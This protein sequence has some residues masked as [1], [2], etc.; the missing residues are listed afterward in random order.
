MERLKAI[1]MVFA[2][3]TLEHWTVVF[4]ASRNLKELYWV[5]NQLLRSKGVLYGL[6][7][8]KV[9][10]FS[11]SSLDIPDHFFDTLP[12][13]EVLLLDNIQLETLS[14]VDSL[15]RLLRNLKHLRYL[16]VSKNELNSLHLTFASTPNI[17]HLILSQNRF[18]N[19]P[20]DIEATGKLQFLDLSYNAI[21]F[22]SDQEMLALNRHV[23]RVGD[24]TLRLHGNGIACVCSQAAFFGEC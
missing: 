14:L 5:D 7:T 24:F 4:A 22:L 17:S 13:L 19:I 10:A 1:N 18:S 16:D 15:Q 2:G 21:L 6:E 8:L 3:I 9:L 20:F 12:G 11:G 23:T